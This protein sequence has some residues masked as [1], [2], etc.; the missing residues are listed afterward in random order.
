MCTAD[1]FFRFLYSMH[2][3]ANQKSLTPPTPLSLCDHWTE[4]NVALPSR[5]DRGRDSSSFRKQFS[6]HFPKGLPDR[7]EQVN[8]T[9]HN[10]QIL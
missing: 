5:D 3:A 4:I 7:I 1:I 10:A 6:D 8:K 2:E 9:E